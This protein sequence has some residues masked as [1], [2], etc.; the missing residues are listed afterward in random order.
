MSLSMHTKFPGRCI[1]IVL[2]NARVRRPY[3]F[4]QDEIEFHEGKQARDKSGGETASR[5]GY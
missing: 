3:A 2:Y 5:R 4:W 1:Y